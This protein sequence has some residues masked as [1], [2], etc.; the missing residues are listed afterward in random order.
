MVTYL[1]V[2][3]SEE[4]ET[5]VTSP[6]DLWFSKPLNR[7]KW[8]LRPPIRETEEEGTSVDPPERKEEMSPEKEESV[9]LPS[10]QLIHTCSGDI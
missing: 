10:P 4:E 7:K 1:S 5:G 9:C 8:Y 3:Q 2:P 6:D